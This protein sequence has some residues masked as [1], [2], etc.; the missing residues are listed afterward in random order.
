MQFI[1]NRYHLINSGVISRRDFT[2][3]FENPEGKKYLPVEA[4][5]G[6]NVFSDVTFTT[7]FF[8]YANRTGLKINIIDKAGESVGTYVPQTLRKNYAAEMEQIL[9]LRNEK[10]HLRIAKAYQNAN[11]LTFGRCYVIMSA[12]GE[13]NRLVR[14]FR[15]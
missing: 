1:N 11:I 3:L 9:L 12:E 15:S 2:I 6:L 14:R 8:E 4:V 7:G 5:D 13:R 10:E